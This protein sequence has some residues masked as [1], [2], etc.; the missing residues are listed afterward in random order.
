MKRLQKV[1][2]VGIV[3]MPDISSGGG[4]FPKVVRD[5]IFTLDYLGIEVYLLSPFGLDIEKITKFYGKFKIKKIYSCSKFKRFFC[6]EDTLARKVIK[7][8]FKKMAKEV[9]L[10][11][12]MDGRILHKYLPKNPPR[13]IVWRVSP[14]RSDL[15]KFP[16]LHRSYKRKIKDNI[17]AV[18]NLKKER[19][20]DKYDIYPVDN[21]TRNELEKYWKIRL[22]E[23][24]YPGVE[25]DKF[26]YDKKL[27][28]NLII[29]FGRIAKNKMVDDSIKIFYNGTKKFSNY[30]LIIMGG[31]TPDSEDYINYLNQLIKGFEISKRVRII[32]NPTFEELREILSQAKV[33]I[34]SQQGESI[35]LT[36]VEAMASGVIVLTS[37]DC[38]TWDEVVEKGKW[39]VGFDDVEDGGRKLEEILE[40]LEKEKI[41]PKKFMKRAEFFSRENFIKRIKQIINT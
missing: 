40:K 16:N 8:E 4:G 27:K 22:K 38:G 5:L 25:T 34:D 9:D 3:C 33:L 31:S 6:K 28:K 12:D 36:S 35:T 7:K 24:L 29:V 21:Y 32:K 41:N 20:N 19:L 11:I 10:I 2:K 13:Y 39:G 17:K 18:I 1:S 30:E 14:V 15:D 37:K 23:N 26:F